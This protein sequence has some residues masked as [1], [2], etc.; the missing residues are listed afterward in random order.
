MHDWESYNNNESFSRFMTDIDLCAIAVQA[1][2]SKDEVGMQIVN[3]KVGDGRKTYVR[4][5]VLFN[6]LVGRVD[7]GP[8]A[9]P[10]E[11]AHQPEG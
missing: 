8:R 10:T 7:S 11:H 5:E 2:W 6:L 3:P 1:G 9:A 4:G